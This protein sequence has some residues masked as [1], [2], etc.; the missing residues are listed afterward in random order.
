M[1]T[2]LVIT[3]LSTFVVIVGEMCRPHDFLL[4]AARPMLIIMQGIWFIQ[5]AHILFRGGHTVACS[6]ELGA[7]SNFVHQWL[8]LTS[9]T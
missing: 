7:A 8:W 6:I 2:L 4:A 3:I 9:Q 5:V 1:H